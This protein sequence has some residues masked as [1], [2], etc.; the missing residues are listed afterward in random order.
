MFGTQMFDVL[1]FGMGNTLLAVVAIVLG[2]P[3]P[4]Y[5]WFYGERLRARSSL[6]R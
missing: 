6:M 1:G 3:F 4:I 5:L 2:I